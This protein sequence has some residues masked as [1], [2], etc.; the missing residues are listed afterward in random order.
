[1]LI[2]DN[3]RNGVAPTSAFPNREEKLGTRETHK[4][5]HPRGKRRAI[6]SVNS[7]GSTAAS[8]QPRV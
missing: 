3:R 8:G 5:H 7:F 6:S 4:L 1:M 2:P